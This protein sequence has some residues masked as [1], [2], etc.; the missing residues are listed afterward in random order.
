M[1]K[2]LITKNGYEKILEEFKTLLKQ[3]K[4]HSKLI[5]KISIFISIFSIRKPFSY[6]K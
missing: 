4:I 5:N 1:Q 3:K 6:F 2:D